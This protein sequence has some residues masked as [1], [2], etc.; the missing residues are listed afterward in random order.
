LATS[1]QSQYAKLGLSEAVKLQLRIADSLQKKKENAIPAVKAK[2]TL[3]KRTN[4]PF[5]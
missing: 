5:N 2:Q 1:L 4:K 3:L